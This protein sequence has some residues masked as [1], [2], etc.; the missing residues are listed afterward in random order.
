[1]SYEAYRTRIER[2]MD[3]HW[4]DFKDGF[5][6]DCDCSLCREWREQERRDLENV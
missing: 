6:D 5:N 4:E 3:E 2:D 1:M